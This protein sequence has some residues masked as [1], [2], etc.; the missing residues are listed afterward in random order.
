MLSVISFS[1]REKIRTPPWPRDE[2]GRALRQ[3]VLE[4]KLWAEVANASA[5][6]ATGNASI[7]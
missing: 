7:A 4:E 6:S 2:S 1:R 5:I 3:L